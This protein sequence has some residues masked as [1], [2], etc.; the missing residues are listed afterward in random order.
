[1]RDVKDTAEEMENG[2]KETDNT[3]I[4]MKDDSRDAPEGR[5]DTPEE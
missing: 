3:S 5:E 2:A 4:A 1:M